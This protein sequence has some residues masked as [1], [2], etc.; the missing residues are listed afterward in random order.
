[1][2]LQP[3][4]WKGR[5]NTNKCSRAYINRDHWAIHRW[6]STRSIRIVN[7]FRNC[8]C[9][10]SDWACR[11]KIASMRLAG[12]W[13]HLGKCLVGRA[14]SHSCQIR[15][16]CTPEK[17]W[18]TRK[19]KVKSLK[20]LNDSN[21]PVSTRCQSP[22]IQ[23]RIKAASPAQ[24]KSL[25]AAVSILLPKAI[26]LENMGCSSYIAHKWSKTISTLSSSTPAIHV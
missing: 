16:E 7:S 10:I 2:N 19:A 15:A 11:F 25:D 3:I 8:H 18:Y 20:W 21:I 14:S 26:S 6:K 12:C 24:S 5:A 9:L 17:M 22:G 4:S 23:C 13:N 1:M